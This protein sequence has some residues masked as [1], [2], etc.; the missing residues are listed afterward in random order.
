MAPAPDS[1]LAPG[2]A[3]APA[4]SSSSRWRLARLLVPCV[5]LACVLFSSARLVRS[6]A[7]GPVRTRR[8]TSGSAQ[9]HAPLPV[10]L[11]A[12][13]LVMLAAPLAVLAP[14]LNARTAPAAPEREEAEET[15]GGALPWEVDVRASPAAAGATVAWEIVPTPTAQQLEELSHEEPPESALRRLVAWWASLVEHEASGANASACVGRD[16]SGAV[17]VVA[18]VLVVTL[19]EA[20]TT[21]GVDALRVCLSA[22]KPRNK[23]ADSDPSSTQLAASDSSFVVVVDLPGLPVSGVAFASSVA[24][25]DAATI[26]G[27]LVKFLARTAPPTASGIVVRLPDHSRV[28][29]AVFHS[30]LADVGLSP[31]LPPVQRLFGAEDAGTSHAHSLARSL[32]RYRAAGGTVEAQVPDNDDISK[33]ASR[34]LALRASA[35]MHGASAGRGLFPSAPLFISILQHEHPACDP[36]FGGARVLVARGPDGTPEACALVST[37]LDGSVLRLRWYGEQRDAARRSGAGRALLA[38]ARN[39]AQV[40]GCRAVDVGGGDAGATPPGNGVAGRLGAQ[41]AGTDLAAAALP[42]VRGAGR[43]ALVENILLVSKP[44]PKDATAT[45]ERLRLSRPSRR[46]S[47]RAALSAIDQATRRAVRDAGL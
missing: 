46:Q 27:R 33:D 26:L 7:L 36:S 3:L 14:M 12:V 10:V 43:Q 34:L 2:L 8:P 17:A 29:S 16:A 19:G 22:R 18:A 4:R 5:L 9:R 11:D 20:A 13:A 6:A 32:R 47:A 39:M 30:A 21:L 38:H 42:L 44:P 45:T 41:A 24:S 40:R 31:A 1:G 28:P 25:S 15:A 35:V 23:A 37:S